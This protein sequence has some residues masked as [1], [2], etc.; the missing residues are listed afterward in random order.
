MARVSML[1]Q[2]M[3]D[4]IFAKATKVSH[5]KH[6]V[7]VLDGTENEFI[8]RIVSGCVRVEKSDSRTKVGEGAVVNQLSAPQLF[9]EMSFLDSQLPTPRYQ[10]RATFLIWQVYGA[11]DE[12]QAA[13]CVRG[14]LVRTRHAS[15]RR[16]GEGAGGRRPLAFGAERL[17]EGRRGSARVGE[18]LA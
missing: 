9:G 7:I 17:G 14:G 1:S 15:G 4:A 3:L 18:V 10:Q 13:L 8:Y 16:Q 11:R 2:E 6:A 5:E 12:S